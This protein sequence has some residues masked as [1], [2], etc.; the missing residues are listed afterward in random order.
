MALGVE[1]IG[2]GLWCAIMVIVQRGEMIA[3]RRFVPGEHL[4]RGDAHIGLYDLFANRFS[5]AYER[6]ERLFRY[7]VLLDAGNFRGRSADSIIERMRDATRSRDA[8]EK[9]R[10]WPRVKAMK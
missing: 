2:P 1:V 3:K 10:Q 4:L 8:G 7:V 5:I 9:S 6:D